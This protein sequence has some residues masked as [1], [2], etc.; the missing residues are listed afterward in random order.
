MPQRKVSQRGAVGQQLINSA[1][2]LNR[3]NVAAFGNRSGGVSAFC[4]P[5]LGDPGDCSLY[6]PPEEEGFPGSIVEQMGGTVIMDPATCGDLEAPDHSHTIGG[7]SNVSGTADCPDDGD[8]LMWRDGTGTKPG[9]WV[10]VKLEEIFARACRELTAE[11]SDADCAAA[12]GAVGNSKSLYVAPRSARSAPSQRRAAEPVVRAAG[13]ARSAPVAAPAPA[14]VVPANKTYGSGTDGN[15]TLQSD[16]ELSTDMYFNDLKLNGYTLHTNGY[17][18]F[19]SGTLD[20]GRKANTGATGSIVCDGA[21][22]TTQGVGKGG[23]SATL[24]GGADGNA[25][26]TYSI[27]GSAGSDGEGHLGPAAELV[28][29]QEGGLGLLSELDTAVRMRALDGRRLT[30]GAGGVGE[31]AG[32]GGGVVF[33]AARNTAL[34]GTLRARGGA[35]GGSS[36]G[37]GGGG[38]VVFIHSGPTTWQFDVSGG[39]DTA[40]SGKVFDIR[41]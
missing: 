37:A 4:G 41:A 39:D 10:P 18:L 28:N 2:A 9:E 22:G 33:V 27:S 30:G 1:K 17:R 21:S 8:V 11:L 29:E 36:S 20:A 40:T 6:N 25:T 14:A 13:N 38:A 26:A 32:G 34:G 35:A 7:L 15:L 23:P 5:Q 24:G 16:S 12:L 19:V 3:T 31:K